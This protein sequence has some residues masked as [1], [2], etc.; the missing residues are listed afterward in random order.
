[1]KKKQRPPRQEAVSLPPIH[2]PASQAMASHQNKQLSGLLYSFNWMCYWIL[3]L[4]RYCPTI[5]DRT[6]ANPFCYLTIELLYRAGYKHLPFGDCRVSPKIPD[7][8][9]LL[10]MR[11]CCSMS[12][13]QSNVWHSPHWNGWKKKTSQYV[14]LARANKQI[15]MAL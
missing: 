10:K 9:I 8:C 11:G 15:N 7:Q 2:P 4:W 6:N 5:Q 12:D 3:L 14:G 13:R 1:M